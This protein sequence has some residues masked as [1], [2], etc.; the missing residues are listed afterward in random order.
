MKNPLMVKVFIF[1]PGQEVEKPMFEGNSFMSYPG[2][3]GGLLHLKISMKFK[4]ME[5]EDVLLLYNGQRN[6]PLQGDFISLAIKNT[7]VEFR[8]NLGS[9]S[10]IIRSEHNVTIGQW[11]T[12]VAERYRR[13]GSLSM[14]G[15]VAVK[16]QSPCCAAGLNLA[17]PLYIGG[18]EDFSKVSVRRL[19]VRRGLKGCVSNVL[20][21]DQAVDL[22]NSYRK[23]RD[24][25]QCT[26]DQLPCQLEPCLYNGTCIPVGKSDFKCLCSFGYTGKR[27]E[28]TLVGP[29]RNK[30]CLNKG[31]PFPSSG[32]TC[33]CPLGYGGERCG[34]GEGNYYFL[35]KT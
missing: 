20:I 30:I 7:K 17:L 24:I 4:I 29:G 34:R 12:V 13:D 14:D 25:K 16:D 27:C 23:L 22:V 33:A 31:I 6:M 3:Q 35:K 26:G 1:N 21:D 10:A 32:R 2:I 15:G 8:F 19:A 5:L 11:H 28:T 9:G 18:V